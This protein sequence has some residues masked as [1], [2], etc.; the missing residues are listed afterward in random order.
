M[1][2]IKVDIKLEFWKP[3]MRLVLTSMHRIG[4]ASV[5][6]LILL[7]ITMVDLLSPVH[8]CDLQNLERVSN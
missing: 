1:E 3:V 2:Q 8:V 6:I 4:S 5:I 7:V